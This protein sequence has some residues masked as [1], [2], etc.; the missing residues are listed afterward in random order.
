MTQGGTADLIQRLGGPG[1]RPAGPP[2]FLIVRAEAGSDR[3]AAYRALRRR[4]FVDQQ[5]LFARDDGD[6][7]DGAA[8]TIVLVAVGAEGDVLGGVR[9]H[10]EGADRGLGWW[11]GS[12]LVVTNAA[13]AARGRVGA[14]LVRSACV[15]AGDAGALRFDAHV[16]ADHVRFFSRLGWEPVR[17]LG[18]HPIAHELM[19]WPVDRFAELVAATKSALGPLLADLLGSGEGWTGDDGVPVPGASGLIAATDAI[20][21][22]MVERDPEWAGWCG[23]LVTA[24]DLSAM[25]ARPV[26]ALDTIG[27]ADAAHAARIVRGLRAGAEAFDLPVLGGHTTLGVPGSLGVTGLGST[28]RPVPAGGGS[29]GDVLTLTADLQGD[30][31]PGYRARQWDSTSW[32]SHDEL[33]AMLGAVARA[34]PRAAKDV[35]MA[36]AVGTA[37]MLAEASGCGVELDVAAVPRPRDVDAGDWLTC[38]PGFAMLTADRPGAPP[39][40]AGPAIGAAVGRLQAQPGVRL[41]WPDGTVT[42][43]LAGPVTG[44]GP[45]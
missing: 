24:H 3:L 6:E 29:P 13:G 9:L 25:G 18:G 22:Q 23:M 43:A 40:P 39:L 44:L 35:S 42:V 38:F 31:R 33:A 34:R 16:Q 17:A 28:E 37:G 36:G 7:H 20:L 2:P 5:E 8:H 21:P 14:A 4:A 15:A 32:R 27:A 1:P 11:R 19:R 26:G 30:W 45:A 12:R 10:P 41:R